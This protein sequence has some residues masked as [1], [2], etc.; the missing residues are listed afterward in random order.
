MPTAVNSSGTK[1]SSAQ[2]VYAN[3]LPLSHAIRFAN[4]TKRIQ[5]S[6]ETERQVRAYYIRHGVCPPQ[7]PEGLRVYGGMYEDDDALKDSTA[8]LRE[9]SIVRYDPTDGVTKKKKR[10]YGQMANDRRHF[11]ELR[12]NVYDTAM[13][14]GNKTLI[15]TLWEDE[16]SETESESEDDEDEQQDDDEDGD[17][18]DAEED[19]DEN[20]EPDNLL[21]ERYAGP[22]LSPASHGYYSFTK[23]QEHNPQL[24]KTAGY[25]LLLSISERGFIHKTKWN[26]STFNDIGKRLDEKLKVFGQWLSHEKQIIREMRELL[27]T[28]AEEED[29][30]SFISDDVTLQ[31]S[32]D[33]LV[34]HRFDWSDEILRRIWE[35]DD[36]LLSSLPLL[37][38]ATWV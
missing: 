33:L 14:T 32:K 20:E 16:D 2:Q 11:L 35:W 30:E 7:F 12:F 18:D 38:K 34:K 37:I 15:R 8:K 28:W 4:N 25:R 27:N 22:T 24:V 17:E 6:E 26:P 10:W 9:G 23:Y 31:I 5:L 1:T 13:R 3:T 21:N 19:E 36:L 29:V